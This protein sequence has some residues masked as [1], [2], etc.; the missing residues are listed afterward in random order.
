MKCEPITTVKTNDCLAECKDDPRVCK[1]ECDA[2]SALDKALTVDELVA[3]MNVQII[4][5]ASNS[6]DVPPPR[7]RFLEQAAAKF[8]Q[9]KGNPV[10]EVGGHTDNVGKDAA[11]AKLSE[12]RANAVRT[13]LVNFGVDPKMLRAQGFG[14]KKPKTGNNTEE[15]RF[16]NRRIEYTVIS[17]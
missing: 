10:V 14:S 4:N 12:N 13:L 2:L 15:G 9:L 11:N 17:R 5:F 7:K 3:A 1:A 6:F 8:K 16:Q